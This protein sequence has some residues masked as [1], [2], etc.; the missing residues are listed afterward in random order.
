MP[1]SLRSGTIAYRGADGVETGRERFELIAHPGGHILRAMCEIDAPALVRDVTLAMDA[2]WRP[3]D[4]FC[5]IHLAGRCAAAQWFDVEDGMVRVAGRLEGRSVP[6]QRIATTG[7][8]PYLGL[9]P[10]QGD[11]L[12]TMLRGTD[13][14]GRFLPIAA[15]T[16][17]VSPN[18]D[19]A[20]G[21][22][23]MT[24]DVAFVGET[25][26]TVTAGS[27]PARRYA[28]RWRADWPPADLWVRADGVFLRMHWAWIE[29]WYELAAIHG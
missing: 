9:H 6:E 14:P 10:L 17:S 27:F 28:L 15:V 20:L 23:A 2:A 16:N 3:L 11:A 21:T 29:E 4:G 19:E 7:R 22:Q 1:T 8:L 13:Q 24:I 5:R 25:Q 12:I 18:G 26:V